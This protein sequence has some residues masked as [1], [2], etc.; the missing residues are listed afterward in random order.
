MFSA[1]FSGLTLGLMGLDKNGLE[2]VMRGYVCM[3]EIESYS[4][5]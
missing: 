3:F 2:I 4:L 5:H 1:L